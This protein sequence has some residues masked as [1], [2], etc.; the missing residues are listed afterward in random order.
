M[1]A[2]LDAAPGP[3]AESRGA[4]S[5]TVRDESPGSVRIT[6]RMSTSLPSKLPGEVL[7]GDL[8]SVD[9]PEALRDE[10]PDPRVALAAGGP[11]GRHVDD[12]VGQP[13][14]RLTVEFR[15]RHRCRQRIGRRRE[16]EQQHDDRRQ[17]RCEACT[18]DAEVDH[19]GVF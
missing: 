12:L 15:R 11:V 7:L 6:F 18:V 13:G 16:R 9:L 19:G 17:G 2:A 3:P 10:V 8:A 5:T 14:G 1:A 4:I